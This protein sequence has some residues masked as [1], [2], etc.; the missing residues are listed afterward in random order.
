[1]YW[2]S[3]RELAL[4]VRRRRRPRAHRRRL[5]PRRAAR[6]RVR[7]T[8]TSRCSAC[9]PIG[10]AR[11]SSASAAWT[12]SARA[13]PSSR[14]A[15]STCRCRAASPRSVAGTRASPS[16]ATRHL[17][18]DGGGAPARLHDQ[19]DRPRSAHR[20]DPRSVR[21]SARPRATAPADGRRA[22]VRGRQPA[23]AA[24]ASSSRRDSTSPWT[25][26]RRTVC[27]AIPLDDLPAE[28]VWGEIE[29]LLLQAE[30]PSI[31]LRLAWDLGVVA[32]LLPELV[33]LATC[34]QDPEWHP[35]GD[36]WTH[37]LMVVD[38]ARQ[39][40]GRPRTRPGGRDDAGR[41]VSR[42]RQAG[43][44]GRQRRARSV[45]GTRRGRRADRDAACSI[46]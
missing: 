40:I 35:E 33:P 16:K 19:R 10:C 12:P 1:M 39:R 13:S 3:R 25:R 6:R 15:T 45:A 37:T 9:R 30:R 23:R 24:R 46:G 42:P 5:G 17:S 28:R 38:E 20:R 34:P 26:R 43:D 4:A 21:R 29:K 27:R 8:S 31:G 11:S 2:P 44:D 36:V 41:A 7:R 14:S 18:I 22:H 32:R